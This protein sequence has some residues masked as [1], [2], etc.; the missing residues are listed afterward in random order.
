[1]TW[2][3]CEYKARNAVHLT[4]LS[5][6]LLVA[7]YRSAIT[8]ATAFAPRNSVFQL[9]ELQ[10]TTIKHLWRMAHY[11]T[12]VHTFFDL[13]TTIGS[14]KIIG[15]TPCNVLISSTV[16]DQLV[17]ANGKREWEFLQSLIIQY[18]KLCQWLADSNTLLCA[19]LTWRWAT[20]L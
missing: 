6:S 2:N 19:A 3:V 10:H 4:V 20:S 5:M 14:T 11:S 1:M 8:S 15:H 13:E 7:P 12:P 9:W 18:F 16:I 17:W